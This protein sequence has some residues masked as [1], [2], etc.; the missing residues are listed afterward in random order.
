MMAE[1]DRSVEGLVERRAFVRQTVEDM[2]EPTPIAEQWR[3]G[4]SYTEPEWGIFC[5]PCGDN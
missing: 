1:L 3:T 5:V 4:E 2:I